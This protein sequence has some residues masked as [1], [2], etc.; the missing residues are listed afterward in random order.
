MLGI[1]FDTLTKTV[2]HLTFPMIPCNNPTAS[3]TAGLELPESKVESVIQVLA[4]C[5]FFLD[6]HAHCALLKPCSIP[7]SSKTK[8][9]SSPY[10]NNVHPWNLT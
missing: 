9:S 6:E 8:G 5:R 3:E 2:S 1:P 10:V 7:V 4:I